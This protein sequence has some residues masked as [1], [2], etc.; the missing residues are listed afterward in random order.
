MQVSGSTRYVRGHALDS[1]PRSWSRHLKRSRLRHVRI[2]QFRVVTKGDICE[3]RLALDELTTS[4]TVKGSMTTHAALCVQ[5]EG[6]VVRKTSCYRS[7]CFHHDQYV[8]GCQGWTKHILSP[9]CWPSPVPHQENKQVH[10]D[11]HFQEFQVGSWLWCHLLR[12]WTTWRIGCN[13]TVR[14]N[15]F[16]PVV[17]KVKRCKWPV[18]ED[19]YDTALEGIALPHVPVSYTT[20]GGKRAQYAPAASLCDNIVV[21]HHRFLERYIWL[22]VIS[23]PK[24][25]C[26]L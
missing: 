3:N 11:T 25:T 8:L 13:G 21:A 1:G 14:M 22:V 10:E 23:T 18:P 15:S 26:L 19:V 24:H 20:G 4:T 12:R 9:Q 7:C 2:V 6:L 17:E 5:S 16:H